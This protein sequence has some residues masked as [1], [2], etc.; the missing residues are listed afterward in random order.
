MAAKKSV[1]VPPAFSGPA[2][3][4]LF[5]RY[6]DPRDVGF[7]QKWITEWFVQEQFPWFPKRDIS[8][9]KHFKP[10]LEHAFRDLAVLGLHEQIRSCDKA[11]HIRPIRGS[12]EVLSVHSWGCAVDLNVRE[13]PLGSSGNWSKE[14]IEVMVNSNIFCGQNWIGRKDPMHF[15]M[16]NG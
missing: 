14:F 1:P 15:A 8:V 2:Q 10:F 13:N 12:K 7:E 3:L 9:H 5:T 16:V 6:G 4:M 11:F